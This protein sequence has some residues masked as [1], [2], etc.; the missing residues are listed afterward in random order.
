MSLGN[1]IFQNQTR[2]FSLFPRPIPSLVFYLIPPSYFP[3]ITNLFLL[4]I[5]ADMSIII[6]SV[7]DMGKRAPIG[8]RA[9]KAC[10]LS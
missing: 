8:Y 2:H 10:A 4:A 5:Y 3:E 6:V 9:G 7:L 1:P